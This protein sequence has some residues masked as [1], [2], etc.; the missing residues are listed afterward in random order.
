VF[1]PNLRQRYGVDL[2]L[3]STTMGFAALSVDGNIVTDQPD[4][5]A[6]KYIRFFRQHFWCYVFFYYTHI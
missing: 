3:P 1:E 2:T 4:G 6:I 5:P